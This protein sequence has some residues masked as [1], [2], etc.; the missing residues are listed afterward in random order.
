[1]NGPRLVNA[2][3][4][5]ED[6]ALLEAQQREIDAFFDR[7]IPPGR[8]V[9]L[10]QYPWD[11]NV[12]NH[13]M[14]LA[15]SD[16]LKRRGVRIAYASHQYNFRL[17]D[18]VRAVGDGPILFLGG[19]TVSRLWPSHANIKRTVA[20][21]CPSNRLISLPSTM[22]FVDDD[23]RREAGAMFGNHRDVVMMARDPVS[24]RSAREVFPKSVTVAAIH[25]SAFRLPPQPR[26]GSSIHDIIWLA[27]SDKEGVGAGTPS[28][29]HVFDWSEGRHAGHF[30]V[31]R[32][33]SRLRISAPVLSPIVNRQIST[34]YDWVSRRLLESGNRALDAGKVLVTDRMHPHVLAAL[35]SQP[36]VLL[37][38]RFGKNRAVYDYS[39]RNYS[40][41]HW[42]DTP[43]EAL[44]LARELARTSSGCAD[45]QRA[46][47]AWAPPRAAASGSLVRDRKALR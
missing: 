22:L 6:A 34:C 18:M 27:R 45:N 8:P 28:D 31:N 40:T 47:K 12:G 41:V 2:L 5:I 24:A 35:R 9:A 10:L 23:D 36:C 13:M 30:L 21:A 19:V 37:P 4:T 16:H 46:A 17:K 11:P 44:E 25:D 42:A 3:S 32:I 20:A 38:D 43:R 33:L 15:I 26:T 14:W 7:Y 1:M 39:S 29:V